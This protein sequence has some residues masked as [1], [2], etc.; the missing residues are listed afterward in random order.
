MRQPNFCD[1]PADIPWLSFTPFFG[2]AGIGETD[3]VDVSVDASGLDAGDYQAYICVSTNDEQEEL[4]Q[5]PFS[6]EVLGDGI[7]QD[8]FEG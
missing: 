7:Y 2:A 3:T 5:I 1:A 6:I 4:I 8:R